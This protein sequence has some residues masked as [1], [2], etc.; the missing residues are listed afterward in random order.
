MTKPRKPLRRKG[1]VIDL[2]YLYANSRITPA[3]CEEWEWAKDGKGYG[4]LWDG[5]RL[6]GT[7]VLAWEL[8]NGRKAKNGYQVNHR[9]N[10]SLCCRPDHLYEGTQ[11]DNMDDAARSGIHKNEKNGRSKLKSIQEAIDIRRRY[12]AGGITQ[13]NLGEEYGVSGGAVNNIVNHRT[14][15]ENNVPRKVNPGESYN[16]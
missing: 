10:N 16:G 1:E 8:E 4:G 11:Q 15:K 9:C 2:D 5:E 14:W 6:R 12:A 3:G 13:E 7:H